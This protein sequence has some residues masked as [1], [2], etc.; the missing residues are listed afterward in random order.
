MLGDRSAMDWA[1]EG[2]GLKAHARTHASAVAPI[3][4]VTLVVLR[5]SNAATPT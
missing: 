1:K 5:S 2:A 3:N 4:C